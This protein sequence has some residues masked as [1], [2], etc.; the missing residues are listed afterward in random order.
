MQTNNGS[1]AVPQ[2]CDLLSDI[3]KVEIRHEE[4][5]SV[6]DRTF[7]ENQQRELYKTLDQLERWYKVFTADAERFRE[8]HKISYKPDGTI[9][10]HEPSSPCEDIPS[11]YRGMEFTPFETINQLVKLY[12]GAQ[13]AFAMR[14]VRYF[15]A[16]YNVTVP[17][18]TIENGTLALGT[19]PVYETFVSKV[20][21]HLGGRSFRITA[22]EEIL[23]RLLE[24]VTPAQWATTKPELKGNKIV[25]PNIIC[26]DEFYAQNFGRNQIQYNWEG[27]VNILC[28]GIV[29]G[30]DCKLNGGP[31][32]LSGF[33]PNNVDLKRWYCM[34]TE[35]P[36][37]LRFFKNGRIDARFTDAAMAA[38]CFRRL[39]LDE[40]TL[41]QD[42]K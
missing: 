35:T 29:L 34:A 42:N 15:N 14:I 4:K 8:S 37:K 39:H 18:P 17:M 25:F 1:A 33:N 10:Y 32:S 6:A 36:V 40:I 31:Q 3:L 30:C 27:R 21:D 2:P 13:E 26:F 23:S 19:R 24:L 41:E 22:E 9:R 5:I 16:T 7:C 20:I 28:E 11:D 38:E 12:H